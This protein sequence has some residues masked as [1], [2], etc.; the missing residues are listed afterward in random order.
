MPKLF[1]P[2]LATL[3]LLLSLA[4]AVA[5]EDREPVTITFELS[6]SGDVPSE[7]QFAILYNVGV[8]SPGGGFGGVADYSQLPLCAPQPGS[9]ARRVPACES[10]STYRGNVVVRRGDRVEWRFFRSPDETFRGGGEVLEGGMTVVGSYTFGGAGEGD[11][12]QAT[13]MPNTGAGG[14]APATHAE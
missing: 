11:G 9:E 5:Q 1:A 13:H 3:V 14:L 8:P 7:E 12:E 6:L 10:K 4:P 2:L